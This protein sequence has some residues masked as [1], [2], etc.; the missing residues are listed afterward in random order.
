MQSW[1]RVWRGGKIQA[2]HGHNHTHTSV[3]F[4]YNSAENSFRSSVYTR[5]VSDIFLLMFFQR[6]LIFVFLF[7]YQPMK[8]I[9]FLRFQ[10]CST[11]GVCEEEDGNFNR[12]LILFF[13]F[14]FNSF[15]FNS[16]QTWFLFLLLYLLFFVFSSLFFYSIVNY[17][18]LVYVIC[19]YL[20]VFYFFSDVCMYLML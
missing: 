6:S 12:S 7:C 5:C 13:N 15:Q 4:R 8:K 14:Q 11:L 9:L 10:K 19:T 1:G 20:Y 18:S 17:R 2:I 3:H 16:F